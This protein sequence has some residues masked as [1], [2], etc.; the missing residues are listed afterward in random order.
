VGYPN[1]SLAS[2]LSI[3]QDSVNEL[4]YHSSVEISAVQLIVG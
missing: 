1:G 4:L 2:C 3:V